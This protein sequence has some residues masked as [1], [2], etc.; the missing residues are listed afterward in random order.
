MFM[1]NRDYNLFT[2]RQFTVLTVILSLLF[3]ACSSEQIN[4]DF[5]K[6]NVIDDR[7]HVTQAQY[8]MGEMELVELTH[9]PFSKTVK[10]NGLLDVP[11][12][13]NATVSAY[14]GG[15][16]K[17]IRLLPGQKIVQGQTLFVLENPEYVE[18][19][20]NFLE[21]KSQLNYLKLD[22]ERQKELSKENITSQKNYLKA[23]SE[24]KITL[25]RYESLRKRLSLMNI[26]AANITESNLKST[27][28]VTSPISGYITSVNASKGMF[29]NPSDVA[30]TIMNTDHMHIE[31]AIFEQD[32][33]Y[34]KEK[35]AIH[36]K[37]QND[38]SM[39][40]DAEVYLI[41][42]AI[43]PV[44][45]TVKV[46]CH[47]SNPSDLKS[48]IP[49]MYVEAEIY[50]TK[51]SAL[52]LPEDAV[53]N[54]GNDYFVL[55]LK[56]KNSKGFVFDKVKVKLGATNNGFI[57]ILNQNEFSK[58]TKFLGKGAFNLIK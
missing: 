47:L 6:Q 10:A 48:L 49:G 21:A 5:E 15:Y 20:Q 42:K 57:E 7:I 43:D 51:D 23:E 24:Y 18:T 58:G 41:N 50:T 8:Q 45:R 36:F 3:C 13:N 46:H 53:V 14:F 55:V 9:Q 25:A 30:V 37:L 4:K 39:E 2:I 44:K 33:S 54:V 22:Y 52:A 1:K 56:E 40:Y 38:G 28:V 31:L 29:L 16:V 11:P 34:V 27:I 26:S 19:Q 17:E 12:E 35:Q 32:L